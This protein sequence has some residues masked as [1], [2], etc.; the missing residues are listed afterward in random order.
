M[1]PVRQIALLIALLAVGVAGGVVYQ[2]RAAD[3]DDRSSNRRAAM[4]TLI[5]QPLDFAVYRQ[6]LRK[7]GTGRALQSVMLYPASDGR[8]EEVLFEGGQEVET[9]QVLLRLD[10]AEERVLLQSARIEMDQLERTLARYDQLRASGAVSDVVYTETQDRLQLAR[11][12]VQQAEIAL[13]DRLV[14]APFAGAI[15]ISDLHRGDRVTT[16]TEIATLDDRSGIFVDFRVP[17]E[18]ASTVA[19]GD[20]VTVTGWSLDDTPIIGEIAILGSRIDPVSRT[21]AARARIANPQRRLR[22]GAS[23]AVQLDIVGDEYPGVPEVAVLW[24]R[25]GSYVWTVRDDMPERVFVDIVRREKGRALIKGPL[26]RDD[27]IVVEGVQSVRPGRKVE[28]RLATEDAE[29]PD[30]GAG[31]ST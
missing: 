23:Y 20:T 2:N 11:L 26:E 8:V 24:S 14:R 30:T 9:D 21:L 16:D 12:R 19:V 13:E 7:V 29:Q 3:G 4:A 1:K 17:E 18:F 10:D 15:G 25:D 5:V 6:E 27:L 28:T 22:P 31:G